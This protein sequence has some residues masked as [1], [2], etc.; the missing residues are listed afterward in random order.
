VG[1]ARRADDAGGIGVAV[2]GTHLAD[3]AGAGG[4]GDDRLPQS[5]PLWR[6]VSHGGLVR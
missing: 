1:S 4:A 3:G 5:V 6:I 2:L